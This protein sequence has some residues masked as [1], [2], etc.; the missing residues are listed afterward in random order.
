MKTKKQKRVR[1]SDCRRL[2]GNKGARGRH[3]MTQHYV[4]YTP[5]P[6]PPEPEMK[7]V[8]FIDLVRNSQWGKDYPVKGK[9]NPSDNDIMMG[10]LALIVEELREIKRELRREKKIV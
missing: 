10:L 7:H 5:P 1:C 8:P 4:P 9:K 6:K 3:W 2:F